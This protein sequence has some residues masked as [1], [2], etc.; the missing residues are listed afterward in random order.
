MSLINSYTIVHS[1]IEKFEYELSILKTLYDKHFYNDSFQECWI[2]TN[3]TLSNL[4]KE[5]DTLILLYTNA[6]AID[7][8]GVSYAVTIG[9]SNN[10]I[11]ELNNRFQRFCKSSYCKKTKISYFYEMAS[12][13]HIHMLIEVQPGVPNT[14]KRAGDIRDRHGTEPSTGK[15]TNFDIRFLKSG[16]DI[17]KWKSYISKADT[18]DFSSIDNSDIPL[19]GFIDS[20]ES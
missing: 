9:S 13:L 17:L 7:K 11:T 20:W 12:F 10:D 15:K 2:N 3:D 6:E 5:R 16:V 4:Y 18:K 1:K 19:S 14:L 8:K